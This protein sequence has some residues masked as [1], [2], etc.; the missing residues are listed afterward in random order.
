MLILPAAVLTEG[1]YSSLL[2][3]MTVHSGVAKVSH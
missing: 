1:I 3:D 2:G